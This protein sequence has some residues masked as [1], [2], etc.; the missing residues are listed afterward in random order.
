VNVPALV[1]APRSP[2]R[3]KGTVCA[4][5]VRVTMTLLVNR[6]ASV[7]GLDLLDDMASLARAAVNGASG[8]IAY[9]DQVQDVGLIQEV[10]GLEYLA[11]TLDITMEV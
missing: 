5:E 6:N 8:L 10:G 11:A 7:D 1:V 3:V 4:E 9:V 2:Y